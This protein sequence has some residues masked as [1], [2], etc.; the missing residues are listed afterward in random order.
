MNCNR[1]SIGAL[2]LVLVASVAGLVMTVKGVAKVQGIS[3]HFEPELH[4]PSIITGI[5]LPGDSL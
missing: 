3:I 4:F 2:V 1:L 5:K